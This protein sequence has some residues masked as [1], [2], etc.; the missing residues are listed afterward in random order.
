MTLLEKRVAEFKIPQWPGVSFHENILV[1]QIPADTD[2]A[3]KIGSLY[4]PD[5]VRAA[6]EQRSPRG[7]IVS[8]GWKALDVLHS[9]GMELGEMIWFADYAPFRFQTEYNVEGDKKQVEFFFLN[10][11]SIKLSEDLQG[12]I[13]RGEI[14]VNFDTETLQHKIK[15]ATDIAA[16]STPVDP[17]PE[18]STVL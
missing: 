12:R 3:E 5:S 10:V 18:Y 8:A 6:K 11:G 17:T 9:H 4:V 7:V 2:S 16:S 1:Y 15:W 13:D 14:V